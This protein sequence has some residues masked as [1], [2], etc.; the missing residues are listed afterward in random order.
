MADM[1]TTLTCHT[2]ITLTY[3][4]RLWYSDG[5]RGA[6]IAG[7]MATACSAG[8]SDTGNGSDGAAPMI[9]AG[10]GARGEPEADPAPS[11]TVFPAL[12]QHDKAAPDLRPVRPGR[13][14][15]LHRHQLP[16]HHGCGAGRLPRRFDR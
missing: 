9:D 11:P 8:G 5:M 16:G 3:V 12:P 6:L 4:D 2:S 14:R 7:V 15:G 13:Q 1:S 10:A